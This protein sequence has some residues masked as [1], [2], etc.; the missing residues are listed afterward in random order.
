VVITNPIVVVVQQPTTAIINAIW[1]R[2]QLPDDIILLL[3]MIKPTG[4]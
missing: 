1:Q 3:Q 2:I 4:H